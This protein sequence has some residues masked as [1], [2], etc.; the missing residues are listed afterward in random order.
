[1]CN[2]QTKYKKKRSNWIIVQ[3]FEKN[4]LNDLRNF[5]TFKFCVIIYE[6]RLTLK[7]INKLIIELNLWFQKNCYWKYYTNMKKYYFKFLMKLIKY[8]IF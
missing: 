6:I 3:N 7:K 2:K 8:K 4:Q 5:L 1:M